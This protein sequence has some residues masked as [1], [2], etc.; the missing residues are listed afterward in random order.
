[1][2]NT[3]GGYSH[4]AFTQVY[5]GINRAFGGQP[6]AIRQFCSYVF[7]CVKS[8]RKPNEVYEVSAATFDNLLK[9]FGNSAAGNILC[10]TILQHLKI[11]SNEFELLKR[12]ALSHDYARKLHEEKSLIDADHLEKYGLIEYD[13]MT[14]YVTFKINLIKEY[15]Q[16][17]ERK[18]PMDM[19]DEERT[20]YIQDNVAACEKKLKAYIRNYYTYLSIESTGRSVIKKFISARKIL[21]NSAAHI[22]SDPDTCDFSDYFDHKKY[23]FYFS[24]VRMIIV[25]NW[26]TLGKKI[27][28]VGI[29]KSKF[30]SCME[31]LNAGRNDADHYDAEDKDAPPNWKI[32]DETIK[33]FCAAIELFDKFFVACNL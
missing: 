6:Y 29:S 10:E 26:D 28:S 8:L 23:I 9:E 20:R 5:S 31:E 25:E 21:V 3:L 15:I 32:S 4:I 1:M 7:S 11:F 14:H 12:L 16:K 17:N 13:R 30:T 19:S 2:I 22:K 18:K 27:E 24:T 33:A